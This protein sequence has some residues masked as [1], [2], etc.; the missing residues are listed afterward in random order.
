MSSVQAQL[1]KKKGIASDFPQTEIRNKDR[2][3]EQGWLMKNLWTILLILIG[4]AIFYWKLYTPG[5]Q[6]SQVGNWSRGHWLWLGIFFG[7]LFIIVAINAKWLGTTVKTLRTLMIGALLLL[8][9]ILPAWFGIVDWYNGPKSSQKSEIPLASAP[10]IIKVPACGDSV[11]LN[12]PAGVW[13]EFTGNG[14]EARCVFPDGHEGSYIDPKNPCTGGY[15]SVYVRDLSGADN[16]VA[17]KYVR[18]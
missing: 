11:R 6:L 16:T 4:S 3:R 17:Y 13:P 18:R 9:I 1:D 2:P 12:P 5:L 10:Q 7:I 8:F 15:T 14:F